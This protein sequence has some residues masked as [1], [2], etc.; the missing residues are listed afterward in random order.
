[1]CQHRNFITDFVFPLKNLVLRR[2]N[3][4]TPVFPTQCRVFSRGRDIVFYTMANESVTSSGAKSI[5][6]MRTRS[7]S[8][9]YIYIMGFYGLFRNKWFPVTTA[10]RVLMLRMEER[11]PVWKVAEIYRI[12]S[13]GQPT[14]SG[15][16]AWCLGEVLTT[17][18]R[19]NL[20]CYEI[21]TQKA[22]DLDSDTCE[23]GNEHS[24]SI[25]CG[26]FLD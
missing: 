20:S 14:I 19:K 7:L 4:W 9:V 16:P 23:C 12:S 17:P 3:I 11:P 1:L 26:E 21:F 18:Y 10:W 22:S 8:H 5:F 25:K 24:G 13:S 6:V 2:C 15:L